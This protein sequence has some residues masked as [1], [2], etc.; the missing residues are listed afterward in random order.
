MGDLGRNQRAAQRVRRVIVCARRRNGKSEHLT[1]RGP[2]PLGAFIVAHAFDLAKRGKDL[3]G[4]NLPDGLIAKVALTQ[5]G[6]EGKAY[7]IT[8][9]EAFGVADAAKAIGEATG[10]TITYVDV[11]EEAA[12]SGMAGAGMPSWMVDAMMELHAIDKAGYA[13][14]VTDVVQKLTGRAPTAFPTFAKE[15]AARWKK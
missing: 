7:D 12:R 14:A 8:G 5:T 6:H 13:S 2:Q 9:G 15:N 4:R 11:P 1:Y 3:R 10:R